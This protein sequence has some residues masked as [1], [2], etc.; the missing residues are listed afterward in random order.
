MVILIYLFCIPFL[1]GCNPNKDGSEKNENLTAESASPINDTG[2]TYGGNYPDTNNGECIGETILEQDCSMGRDVLNK[3]QSDGYV[4]FSFKKIDENGNKLLSGETEWS[5]IKDNVTGLMWE[6]KQ[7]NGLSMAGDSF[8]WYSTDSSTNGGREG[9]QISRP[10]ICFGYDEFDSKTYCN[11]QA[12]IERINKNG[13]C[14]YN[15]WRLPSKGELTSIINYGTNVAKIDSNFFPRN[16]TSLYWTS[17]PYA[18]T[19]EHAWVVDFHNGES[20][21]SLITNPLRVRLVR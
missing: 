14:G 7:E 1:S 11:T 10:F 19:Q 9:D 13:L 3:E 21:G 20:A 6:T 18:S 16:G 8:S 4:G 17:T 5:C 15:D 2:I 12:F